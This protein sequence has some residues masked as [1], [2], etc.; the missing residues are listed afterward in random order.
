[1]KKW[2]KSKTVWIGGLQLVS[3]LALIVVELLQKQTISA[4][5]TQIILM[6]NGTAMLFLRWVTDKP[7]TSPVAV[8]DKMRPVIAYN[9]KCKRYIVR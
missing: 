3:T 2:W 1:M 9:E 7:I 6:L 8:M 5:P 4:D